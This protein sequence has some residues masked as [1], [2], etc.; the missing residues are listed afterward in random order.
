MNPR[1]E[2]EKRYPDC[3]F[4]VYFTFLAANKALSLSGSHKHHICPKKQFPEYINSPEN[5]ILLS[6]E[7]HSIAHKLP[8]ASCG[9]KSPPA[10]YFEMQHSAAARGG[11]IGGNS[12]KKNGTG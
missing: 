1:T 5:K 10:V 4:S 3:A 12:N 6:V 9:I 2:L 8:E 11:K 7:A